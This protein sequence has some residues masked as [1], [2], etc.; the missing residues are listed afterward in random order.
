ME[1]LLNGIYDSFPSP[2][3]LFL[4]RLMSVW[5][6]CYHAAIGMN[7]KV[8]LR[9]SKKTYYVVLYGETRLPRRPKDTNPRTFAMQIQPSRKDKA[10]LVTYG[11][12]H[13]SSK[14]L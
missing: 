7:G 10:I 8:S 14:I 1:G 13:R 5:C 2:L 12:P 3:A 6:K 9:F 4:H 11:H